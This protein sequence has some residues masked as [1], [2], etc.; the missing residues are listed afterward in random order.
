MF[1]NE[2]VIEKQNNKSNILGNVLALKNIV[3]YIIYWDF[4]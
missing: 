3:I 1:Q 2:N 4:L